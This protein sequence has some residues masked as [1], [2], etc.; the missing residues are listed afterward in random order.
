MILFTNPA[1]R[2]IDSLDPCNLK[3]SES[4][5]GS[6]FEG[7]SVPPLLMDDI[8]ESSSSSMHSVYCGD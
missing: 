3:K 4:S 2:E 6:F 7:G 8:I 1:A 5:A